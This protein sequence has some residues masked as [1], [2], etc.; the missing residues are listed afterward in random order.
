MSK[1]NSLEAALRSTRVNAINEI[2]A[3]ERTGTQVIACEEILPKW[4]KAGPDG[5]GTHKVGEPCTHAGQ[6][7]RCCQEHSTKNNPDIEPGKSPAHWVPYHTTD[8]AKAKPYAVPQGSRGLYQTGECC[9]WEGQVRRS[10]VDNN[11]YSPAD[12]PDNWEA[13]SDLDTGEEV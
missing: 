2:T 8:P 1:Y 6:S 5:D 9:L 10:K 3:G 12:Y 7:W 11:P 13:V 4:T